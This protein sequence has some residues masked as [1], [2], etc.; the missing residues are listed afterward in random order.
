M[1]AAR[2]LGL[3]VAWVSGE[4][5]A[6]M[7][8]VESND[9]G[10]TDI[11]DPRVIHLV[12]RIGKTLEYRELDEQYGALREWHKVYEAAQAGIVQAKGAIHHQL[13]VLFPDFSF[14]K[15]FLYGPSGQALVKR[16]G[17]SASFLI[18]GSDGV[19]SSV[20]RRTYVVQLCIHKGRVWRHEVF[21]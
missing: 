5:V 6:K 18:S 3:E 13:N 21:E 15:D 9:S 8:V 11:K 14:S 2:R 7:R 4:A 10:K 19:V 16:Y 20:V 17:A 12:A 1:R